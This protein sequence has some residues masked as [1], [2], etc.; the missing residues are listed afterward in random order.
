M[1]ENR[2][3]EWIHK[4]VF[5]GAPVS[6]AREYFRGRLA[7]F[8]EEHKE[9]DIFLNDL[10]VYLQKEN[11]SDYKNLCLFIEGKSETNW[12]SPGGG[13]FDIFIKLFNLCLSPEQAFSYIKE[14]H[15]WYLFMLNADYEI[16]DRPEFSIRTSTWDGKNTKFVCVNV[17]PKEEPENWDY[18]YWFNISTSLK[19]VEDHFNDITSHTNDVSLVCSHEKL[20]DVLML[21]V[22]HQNKPLLRNVFNIAINELVDKG[23]IKEIKTEC[24]DYW[25]IHYYDTNLKISEEE[26]INR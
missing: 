21:F 18:Y 26:R 17:L 1:E 2:T 23:F 6:W 8:R 16:S 7:K 13:L 20:H 15:K 10:Y 25:I 24:L 3:R 14:C 4:P 9:F 11:D 19:I 22:N 5:H 12:I